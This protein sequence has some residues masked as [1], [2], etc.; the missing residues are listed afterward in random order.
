VVIENL[1][2]ALEMDE[3]LYEL[4]DY[5]LGL[6]CGRSGYL[7]SFIQK[8]SK[9]PDFVLSERQHEA[10][11]L[12]A[13]SLLCIKTCHRRGAAAIGAMTAQIPVKDDPIAN[14]QA[15]S[16]VRADKEREAA[17]GHDGT[18]V[19]HPGL[20]SIARTVFDRLMQGPNQIFKQPKDVQVTATDLLALPEGEI[21]E[22]GLRNNVS[23]SMQYLGAW[24]SGDGSVPINN[25]VVDAAAAEMARAQI[26]QWIRL[27][28][29]PLERF[30][31]LLNEE[32]T[33]LKA[34]I[35]ADAGAQ[36]HFDAAAVLLDQIATAPE[37]VPFLT[38]QAYRKL[39]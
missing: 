26:W 27:Q 8:F 12:H 10:A 35:G 5:A 20:V 7:F 14:E 37:F 18:W 24:L 22:A 3:I 6:A 39:Q 38:L 33:R 25:L 11:S 4:R 13:F 9:R 32:R 17:D 23:V 19:A 28:R 36:G 31:S 29:V 1:L 16:I 30:R 15:M 2:A 21:T 34:S